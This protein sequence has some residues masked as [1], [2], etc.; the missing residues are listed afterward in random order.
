MSSDPLQE[1]EI[2]FTLD[3]QVDNKQLQAVEDVLPTHLN[4][5]P[6]AQRPVF[7]GL[8]LPMTFSGKQNVAAI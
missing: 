6:L 3:E 4:I 7:P 8:A 2:E 5:L 1:N